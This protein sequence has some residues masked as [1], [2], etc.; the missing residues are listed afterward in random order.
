MGTME[1][2]LLAMG[3][4]KVLKSR[5]DMAYITIVRA[6]QDLQATAMEVRHR[7]F[8]FA[9]RALAANRKAR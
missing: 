9:F 8:Y 7:V 5:P 4:V 1:Q 6:E 2:L 3:V